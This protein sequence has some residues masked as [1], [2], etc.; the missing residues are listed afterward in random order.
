MTFNFQMHER[1]SLKARMDRLVSEVET[2]ATELVKMQNHI[3]QKVESLELKLAQ[4]SRK[5][6]TKSNE[7]VK[8]PQATNQEVQRSS[9]VRILQEQLVQKD[10]LF[11]QL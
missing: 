7:W 2:M 8:E 1:L 4:A 3:S 10:K 11:T 5:L 6:K 9:L